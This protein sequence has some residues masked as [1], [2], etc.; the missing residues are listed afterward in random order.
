M[1]DSLL[2]LR[3]DAL[4]T[5]PRFASAIADLA[6]VLRTG[7][8]ARVDPLLARARR[9]LAG[10]PLSRESLGSWGFVP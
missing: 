1:A 7:D 2:L 6:D 10:A 4:E 9:E 5:A 8:V 3:I